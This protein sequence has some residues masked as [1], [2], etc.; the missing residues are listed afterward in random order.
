MF[1][2]NI[3]NDTPTCKTALSEYV[4]HT[5]DSS[6]LFILAICHHHIDSH[7]H[8]QTLTSVVQAKCPYCWLAA[9][10]RIPTSTL[11]QRTEQKKTSGQTHTHSPTH[12]EYNTSYSFL[13][14]IKKSLFRAE[15]IAQITMCRQV[16]THTHTHTHR[17][18]L[19]NTCG[20]SNT[21]S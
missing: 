5:Q 13:V 17:A 7:C 1:T 16:Y 14:E 10:I 2:F 11:D 20:R 9:H 6:W 15:P 8:I 3:I 19:S 12:T 4:L 18:T 21:T